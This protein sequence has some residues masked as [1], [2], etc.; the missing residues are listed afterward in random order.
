MPGL[1]E[2]ITIHKSINMIHHI[3]KRKDNNHMISVDAEKA[4]GKAQHPSLIKTKQN[5]TKQNKTKKTSTK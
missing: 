1:Q 4:F 5:K 2:W 3:N